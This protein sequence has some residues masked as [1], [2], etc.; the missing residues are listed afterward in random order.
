MFRN[1]GVRARLLLAFFGISAFAVFAAVAAM[2]SFLQVGRALDRITA[3]RVPPALASL[4]LS[5]QVERIVAAAPALLTVT[6]ETQHE[7]LSKTI[8]PEVEH[9]A[10]LVADL[11][12]GDL[13]RPAIQQI[14]AVVER[15][16]ANL[17]ALNALVANRLAARQRKRDLLGEL[18]GAHLAT[19]RLLAPGIT[20]TDAK[21]SQWRRTM[22]QTTLSPQELLSSLLSRDELLSALALRDVQSTVTSL[23]DTLLQAALVESGAELPVLAFPLRRSLSALETLSADVDPTLRQ[24]LS[25]RIESSGPSSPDPTASWTR[26]SANS[27]SSPRASAC[28]TKIGRYQLS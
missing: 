13:P 21:I 9:L 7:Q 16:R 24:L 5:G 2:Y 14:K 26:A 17:D 8:A 25:P 10:R 19:Q 18:S 23:N 27:T 22:K 4:E 6:S 11:E 28:S 12:R 1:L 20:V 15:L 3:Q